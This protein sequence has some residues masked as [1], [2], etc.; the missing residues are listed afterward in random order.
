GGDSHPA[1]ETDLLGGS[2]GPRW[3]SGAAPR[4]GMAAVDGVARTA[5]ALRE[6]LHLGRHGDGLTVMGELALGGRGHTD[7][8]RD[9][10][11]VL[12]LALAVL[13]PDVSAREVL[14]LVVLG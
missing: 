8:D 1:P 5:V 14:R 7:R 12:E 9:E 11:D 2:I 13:H 3:R 10:R 4:S 6:L